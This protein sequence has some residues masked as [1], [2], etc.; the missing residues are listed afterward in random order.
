[1]YEKTV[2]VA[3]RYD[4]QLLRLRNKKLYKM[5][6]LVIDCALHANAGFLQ[7]MKFWV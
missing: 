1:M 2:H 5:L 4:R 6:A 7:E 3:N